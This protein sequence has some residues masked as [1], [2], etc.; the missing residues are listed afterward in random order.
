MIFSLLPSACLFLLLLRRVEVGLTPPHTRGNFLFG[1]K[2]KS[3][4]KLPRDR[5]AI[6]ESGCRC[7]QPGEY[8]IEHPYPDDLSM[9]DIPSPLPTGQ[10]SRP[11]TNHGTAAAK[12][13][14]RFIRHTAHRSRPINSRPLSSAPP[15]DYSRHWNN[16]RPALSLK[17][18]A[19]KS[20]Q[21]GLLACR[22]RCGDLRHAQVVGIWVFDGI[23]PRLSEATARFLYGYPI[24]RQFLW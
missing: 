11:G 7:A 19:T 10:E 12:Q 1:Q 4:K 21:S 13:T 14:P 16:H 6:Q 22:E 5:V 3:P 8:A 18:S 15:A 2:R 17:A 23:F 9:P 24:P 20:T